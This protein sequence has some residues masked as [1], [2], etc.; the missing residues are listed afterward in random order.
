MVAGSC[1]FAESSV[2][3]AAGALAGGAMEGVPLDESLVVEG[4]PAAAAGERGTVALV[5]DSDIEKELEGEGEEEREGQG[6]MGRR[7]K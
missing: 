6:G 5:G 1:G 3:A 7:E 4:V 2:E